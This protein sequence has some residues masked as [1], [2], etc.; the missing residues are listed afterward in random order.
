MRGAASRSTA[1]ARAAIDLSLKMDN[2]PA[3]TTTEYV[4]Y[5]AANLRLSGTLEALK[6]GGKVEVLWGVIKP[7]TGVPRHRRR[8]KPDNTIE[9]VYDGVAPPPPPPAP[10]SPF[11]NVFGNLAIDVVAQIHRN[12]WIKVCRLVGRTRRQS[13]RRKKTRADR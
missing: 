3:I 10:P 7:D 5:T 2:W 9:V 1:I 13:S 11:A 6:L 4:A 12:T 8:V